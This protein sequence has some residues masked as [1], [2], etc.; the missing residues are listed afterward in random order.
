MPGSQTPP[1]SEPALPPVLASTLIGRWQI[2]LLSQSVLC[3]VSWSTCVPL[4]PL[5]LKDGGR[6][7]NL[8][9]QSQ[10]RLKLLLLKYRRLSP[11]RL[12]PFVRAAGLDLSL[13]TLRRLMKK[14]GF[15]RCIARIKPLLN[16][17]E[18]SH[19]ATSM[20]RRTLLTLRMTGGAQSLWTRHPSV[21]MELYTPGCPAELEKHG[22]RSARC[23]KSCLARV[24]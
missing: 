11:Q 2:A 21:W 24:R 22:T 6:P 8:P 1:L 5:S 4:V 23:Q 18:L 12:L 14:L 19:F 20:P 16:K 10:H 17:R 9:V 7:P 15:R 3:I 13:A